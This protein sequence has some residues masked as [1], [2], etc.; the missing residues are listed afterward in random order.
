MSALGWSRRFGSLRL[1]VPASRSARHAVRSM[2]LVAMVG[3]SFPAVVARGE[4]AVDQRLRVGRTG[5]MCVRTPCPSRGVFLPVDGGL[6]ER[7]RA[8]LYTDAD[9][10]S[11]P[12]EF[13]GA[14][15]ARQ[16]ASR[17]WRT[18][19]CIEIMG[20]LERD[21]DAWPKLHISHVLGPCR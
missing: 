19:K 13:I 6:N 14:P 9:G 5:I 18:L 12:P 16:A 4:E 11:G 15:A 3:A 7:R 20:H 21:G 10:K 8:L 1:A 2:V 17:A